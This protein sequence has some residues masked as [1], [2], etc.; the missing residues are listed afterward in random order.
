MNS[1]SSLPPERSN[2]SSTSV[3]LG[4]WYNVEVCLSPEPL[5]L[6]DEGKSDVEESLEASDSEE[7]RGECPARCDV[8]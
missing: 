5:S 8:I 4:P 6:V 2:F 3:A 1:D 7:L